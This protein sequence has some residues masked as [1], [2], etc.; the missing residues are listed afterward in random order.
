MVIICTIYTHLMYNGQLL[1]E[2]MRVNNMLT[3]NASDYVRTIYEYSDMESVKDAYKEISKTD[4]F[5]DLDIH[6]RA[7]NAGAQLGD[8]AFINTVK[9]QTETLGLWALHSSIRVAYQTALEV[10]KKQE[11]F[12]NQPQ[13]CNPQSDK[14]QF[15][16][17]KSP[18]GIIGQK[19]LT[20]MPV[21]G[22][23]L[24]NGRVLIE[25]LKQDNN[26]SPKPPS[27]QFR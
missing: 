2:L 3:K 20:V 22:Y 23:N 14:Q 16:G 13:N 6:I 19:S 4:K 15:P 21:S 7:M 8:V 5:K 24:F 11:K 12:N 18:F 10:G 17:I 9:E 27:Q 25:P 26:S 1:I